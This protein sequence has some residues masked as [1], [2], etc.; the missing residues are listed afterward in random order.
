MVS[1]SIKKIK[2]EAGLNYYDRDMFLS[3]CQYLNLT[4]KINSTN[5]FL[6]ESD[7]YE[8]IINLH[9]RYS[10]KELKNLKRQKTCI[11]KYGTSYHNNVEKAFNTTKERYGDG[12]F[13]NSEKAKQTCLERYGVESTNS[14][15]S[16]KEKIAETVYNTYG[17]STVLLRQDVIEKNKLPKSKEQIEKQKE[18]YKRNHQSSINKLENQI[19]I[20]LVSVKSLSL[21]LDRDT[22]TLIKNIK[23]WNINIYKDNNWDYISQEDSEKVIYNYSQFNSNGISLA[24][25][26]IVEYVKSQCNFN[27][28]ENDRK[29]L[30]GKELDIYIPEINL[31]IE[32]N[33]LYWHSDLSKSINNKFR[34][35][36]KTELCNK[37]NI[38]LIHIFSDEWL[39]KKEQVKNLLRLALGCKDFNK[40]YARKCELKNIDI[41]T[42]RAFL[43]KNHLQGYSAANIKIGLFYKNELIECIGFKT[44]GTHSSKP[45]LVRLCTKIGYIVVGG[46]SKLI[47]HSGI[48]NFYSYIDIATR[49]GIGYEKVG[50]KIIKQ[51]PPSFFWVH[52]G[53]EKRISRQVYMKKNIKKLYEGGQLKY[54]NPKETEEI[55]MRKNGFGKIWNCGTFKVEWKE[56]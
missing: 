43:E 15:Q 23:K 42:Y 41:N 17:V 55:N 4:P 14:L 29:V 28:V 45:E 25:K 7:W 19:E 21:F 34:H 9:K 52:M 8:L 37:L 22:S 10:N 20:K 49:T 33:G 48:K 12:N 1:L 11:E 16:K 24:E 47:K 26:E 46:F 6:I 3:D 5:R 30:N 39:Y 32:Y 50:F 38:R 56:I 51:N 44:S 53:N 2:N 13:R 31:A 27:I 40:I 36:E 18:T 35:L 54:F